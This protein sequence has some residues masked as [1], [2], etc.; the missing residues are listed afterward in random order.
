MGKMARPSQVRACYFC[1]LLQAMSFTAVIPLLLVLQSGPTG[2]AR[3]SFSVEAG[4][5]GRVQVNLQATLEP[6]WHLYALQL[7]REDGP[8]P[9]VIRLTSTAGHTG[10]LKVSEPEPVEEMDPNFAMLVRHHSGEPVFHAATTRTSDAAFTLA[11][12]VEY[13]LCNDR[14]CLPPVAV[15]FALEVPSAS[16]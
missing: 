5:E 2:P 9:T 6:G 7:P 14:T 11:G 10:L 8:L 12:E 1:A 16:K 3:W 13:M 15:P 4:E